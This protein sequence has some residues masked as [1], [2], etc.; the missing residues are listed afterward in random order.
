MVFYEGYDSK[1][2]N[3]FNIK[4][5]DNWTYIN[6]QEDEFTQ[7]IIGYVVRQENGK[8]MAFQ[9]GDLNNKYFDVLED[10][11]E[12]IKSLYMNAKDINLEMNEK[13]L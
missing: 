4:T 6:Y 1:D 2:N 9:F 8:Y 3:D 5:I 12:Y 11:I 7:K 13:E 10:G